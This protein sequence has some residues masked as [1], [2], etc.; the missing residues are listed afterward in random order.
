MRVV[1]VIS[2]CCLLMPIRAF[3]QG[4][5]SGAT[6]C[7]AMTNLQISG[8]TLTVTHVEWFPAGTPPPPNFGPN[9]PPLTASLPAYCR[10]DGVI[11]RRVGADGKNYGIGFALALPDEWNG[12]FLFQGGAGLNGVVMPPMGGMAAGGNSA[13]SRGFAVVSTD[14]GHTGQD[15]SFLRE[16]QAAL[17]YAYQAI[18]RVAVLAKQIVAQRYSRPPDRSYFAGCSNGGREGMIVAQRYP[19]YFDGI[20]VGAPAMRANIAGIGEEWA[21][22]TLNQLA[23]KDASGTPIPQQALSETEK[24]TVINALLD[25]CDANDGL[26]DRMIFNRKAC[27]F[28][29]KTLVCSGTR[30]EGCLS[31][32]KAAAIEKVFSGPKDSKGRQVY[33]PFF[34]DTAIAATQPVPGLLNGGRNPLG[35]PFIAT[36]IDVDRAVE[37]AAANPQLGETWTS[38]NLNTFSSRGGKLLFYHGLSD[39]WFSAVDTID[40]YERLT[41]GNGGS[42]QVMN[43][44]RLFL[45]PGMGHCGSGELALDNFDLLGAVVDWVEKGTV[46]NAVIATGRAMPGRSRPLCAYPQYAHYEGQGN[47]E[48]ARNFQCRTAEPGPQR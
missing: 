16:Q 36:A 26:K 6:G 8:V 42:S 29:P 5:R 9:A 34:F 12:R 31:M 44:S 46:P 21:A 20:V 27:R 25:A 35:P 30:Q 2:A 40:Y 3:A 14:T 39:P 47:P 48:D 41:Q 4:T 32:P 7:A 43:W 33:P 23:P 45:A 38:T 18:G 11:D 15:A 22:V 1:L 28:D 10:L 13:L 19:T 24:R 37:A 17:D